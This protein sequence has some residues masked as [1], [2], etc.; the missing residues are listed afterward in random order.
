MGRNVVWSKRPFKI[1]YSQESVKVGR[2]VACSTPEAVIRS[3][4]LA[5]IRGAADTAK[6]SLDGDT[7]AMLHR[8]RDGLVQFTVY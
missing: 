3:A 8:R 6:V 1:L 2:I 4:S 5:V 7:F